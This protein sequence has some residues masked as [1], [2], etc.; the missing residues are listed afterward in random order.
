LG[1]PIP[2]PTLRHAFEKA[3]SDAKVRDFQFRDF[4]HCAHQMGPWPGC[5]SRSASAAS[6]TS[7]AGLPAGTS[8][9][10]M[11]RSADACQKIFRRVPRE[12]G[13]PWAVV[14]EATEVFKN[15]GAR[16]GI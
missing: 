9:F 8:T 6:V 3:V 16:S 7:C 4:R 11:T 10:R 12:I 13:A 1:K 5:R 15:I 2:K 14:S